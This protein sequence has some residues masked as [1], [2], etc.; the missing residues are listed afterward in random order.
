MQ[1]QQHRSA[2]CDLLSHSALRLLTFFLTFSL[3]VGCFGAP[4]VYGQEKGSTAA[5]AVSLTAATAEAFFDEL[6]AQQMQSAHVVGATVAVVKGNALLFAK[7]YGAADLAQQVPVVATQTLFFPGST[8]KLLTWTALMQL[9]EQGKIDLHG[10]VNQYL[11]F[12]IP[13][14]YPEPITIAHLLTHTAGFEEQLAAL[15]VAGGADVQPLGEFLRT[16]LPAR[17]YPPGT[18]FAYSNY[19]TAL[20]GYIVERVSGEVYVD[21]ITKHILE[22]LAMSHSAA[23]QPL[24]PALMADFSKGYHY[25]NGQYTAVDYEWIA[26]VPAA[27]LHTTATD[28]AN[29]M[30]AYLNQGRFGDFQL[31]QPATSA[32]MVQKQF[33][34]DPQVNGVGYGFMISTQNGKTLAWHTGGSAYFNTMLALIPEEQVGFFLSFNTPVGDLYQPLVSFVDH[35]Y[36]A[37][38]MTTVPPPSD[39]AQQIAALSGSYVSARVA[40]HSAQKLATWQAEA[41]TVQP[42][43]DQTLQVGA[44]FYRAA[45]PGI[46]RQVDGPRTLV[47]RTNAA[48][49]VTQL[50]WGQF[51]YFKIP[52]YQRALF[53]LAVVAGALLLMVTG[54]IVWPIAWLVQRRWRDRGGQPLPWWSTVA[55]WSAVLLA[56][57]NTVLLGW[58]LFALLAYA[59]SFVYPLAL[60]ARLTQLW[61]INVPALLLLLLFTGLAWRQRVWSLA[62]RLYYT[63]VTLAGLFVLY[64]LWNWNLL[65]FYILL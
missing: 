60:S 6:I 25:R 62:G 30:I 8:G 29:F 36:P 65:A 34:H 54:V 63:L 55:R 1:D 53:Q 33:A 57:F 64:F 43:P 61:W 16:W 37:P 45:E 56:L 15:L 42:G 4:P 23:G 11:D 3:V 2:E 10:D 24:P 27:P 35:F 52:P 44:R 41:L 32:A 46:F 49:N 20:A 22:P 51:A 17:I 5:D 38:P 58:L 59:E 28:I 13:A 47:Y 39:T 14:T 50:F 21:Y 9:V 19:A 18:T 40:R 12:I 31:V 48:G 26:D 7:G